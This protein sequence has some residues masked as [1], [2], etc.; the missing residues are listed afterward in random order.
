MEIINKNIIALLAEYDCVIVPNFGGFVASYHAAKIDT[1]NHHAYPPL[2]HVLFNKNLFH[3]D[4]LLIH[5]IA[6]NLSVSSNEASKLV[7]NY[8]TELQQTLTSKKRVEIS[9]LGLLYLDDNQQIQFTANKSAAISL[10]AFGLPTITLQPLLN[11]P[12]V[13]E[14]KETPIV[15]LNT[16][17]KINYKNIAAAAILI[18]TVLAMAW[19]P[20]ASS[21]LKYNVANLFSINNSTHEV[22]KE[23]TEAKKDKIKNLARLILAERKI[24]QYQITID[25]LSKLINLNANENLIAETNGAEVSLFL[26]GYYLITGCFTQKNN[27]EKMLNTLIQNGYNNAKILPQKSNELYRVSIDNFNKK[28]KAVAQAE[29]LAQANVDSWILSAN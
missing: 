17:R 4:G 3:N 29:L 5:S 24:N 6:K 14:Q 9:P 11:K 19:L 20:N 12:I 1:E 26:T 7:S 15:E 21:N 8:I 22:I 28:N 23:N 16:K 2:K 27:A 18:P 13:N 25:S 10:N